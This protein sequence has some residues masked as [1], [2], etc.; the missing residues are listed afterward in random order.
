MGAKYKGYCS[1]F[2]RTFWVGK[3]TDD[4]EEFIKVYSSVKKASIKATL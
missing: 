3:K 4:Y 1:D 2:T